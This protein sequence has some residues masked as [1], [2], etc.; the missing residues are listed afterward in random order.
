MRGAVVVSCEEVMMTEREVTFYSE[1]IKVHGTLS[2]PEGAREGAHL[3]G[4]V[5]A[6]GYGSFRDELTGFVELA[7]KL[8]REDMISLRFDFRGCGKTGQAGGIFP[9]LEWIADV[10]AAVSY[11][12]SLGEVDSRRIGTVGMSVGGGTVC[13]VAGIDKRV[14]CTVALAP[15]ADGAWWLEHL[16]KVRQGERAWEVFQETLAK[17]RL[18]R[19]RTGKSAKVAI[20]EVLGFGPEDQKRWEQLLA[21]YPQFARKVYLSSADS[22]MNFKP[23]GL[24]QLAAPRPIRFVH[25]EHDESVP[26]AHSEELYA[27]AGDVKDFQRIKGSPH[28]FWVGGQSEQ[29]QQLAVDWLKEHL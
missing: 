16:W 20:G 11:L 21:R 23:L 27:A 5:L 12:Q 9:H 8:R 17:D 19:A 25:S 26:I 14:K 24:V 29:V 13:Y 15:V 7:E 2:L 3:A 1:G 22:L 6:H 10:L 4:V 18:R 28:C